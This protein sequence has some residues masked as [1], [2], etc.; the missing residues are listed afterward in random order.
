MTNLGTFFRKCYGAVTAEAS[1]EKK[2]RLLLTATVSHRPHI[3]RLNLSQ[4]TYPT[5]A[6][7][8]NLD[9]INVRAYDFYD[10]LSSPIKI[11]PPAALYNPSGI[12]AFEWVDACISDWLNCAVP[13][14][15]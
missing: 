9:W 13:K 3:D 6:I 7:K 1:A 12:E 15:I 8:S 11:T 4:A 5:D 14:T 10:A 2:E